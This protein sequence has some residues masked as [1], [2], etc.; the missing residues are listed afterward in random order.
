MCVFN[1]VVGDVHRHMQRSE[2]NRVSYCVIL[3]VIF[4]DSLFLNL[5]FT[6]LARLALQHV[7]GTPVFPLAQYPGSGVLAIQSSY[8]VEF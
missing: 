5:N 8:Y 2:V 1:H 6:D 7:P 3:H 4:G